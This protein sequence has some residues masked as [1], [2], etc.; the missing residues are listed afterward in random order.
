MLKSF[1]H[2]FQRLPGMFAPGLVILFTVMR[3]RHPVRMCS[4]IVKLSSSLRNGLTLDVRI[5]CG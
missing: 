4:Q 2:V 3:N 5:S 1:A